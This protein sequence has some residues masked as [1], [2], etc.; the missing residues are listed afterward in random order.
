MLGSKCLTTYSLSPLVEINKLNQLDVKLSFF[1]DLQYFASEEERAEIK[2]G[3]KGAKKKE[4][5]KI[6][7]LP[8]F[9][10]VCFNVIMVEENSLRDRVR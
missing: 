3:K 5:L 4:L 7:E 6:S 10:R 9:A 8:S 1:K 2:K